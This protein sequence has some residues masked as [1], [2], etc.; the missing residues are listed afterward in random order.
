MLRPVQTLA[1]G[2]YTANRYPSSR[3]RTRNRWGILV[4]VTRY[5]HD[6]PARV[7]C[8]QGH[9]LS[10]TRMD[11]ETHPATG[12]I[13]LSHEGWEIEPTC[14]EQ[15]THG[16]A[17]RATERAHLRSET[18]LGV[19]QEV[20]TLSIGHYAMRGLMAEAAAEKGLG[21]DRLSF[22]GCL[23]SMRTRMPECPADPAERE[24][25]FRASRGER[26]EERTAPRRNRVSPRVVRV[27]RSKFPKKRP[28]HR[29]LGTLERAFVDT[30]VPLSAPQMA[31][32]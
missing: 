24:S 12:L 32:G 10:T 8:G 16:T 26:A 1:D 4:R 22:L 5:T 2:S 17:P 9:L 29:G 27:K 19:I 31:S 30:I 25:W 14:D 18:P 20:Y 7:G 6:D 3:D 13:R 23:H 15:K 21:P 28:E 11:A